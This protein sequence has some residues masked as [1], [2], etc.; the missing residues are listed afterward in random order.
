M[1]DARSQLELAVSLV[2]KLSDSTMNA[3]DWDV[4]APDSAGVLVPATDLV[5]DDAPWMLGATGLAD[6]R[7]VHAKVS[8]NVAKA[9]NIASRRSK[10]VEDQ[11]DML[12]VSVVRSLRPLLSPPPPLLLPLL[13]FLSVVDIVDA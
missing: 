13:A 7:F 1:A 12:E 10:M 4:Y 8:N 9:V 6:L 5:Y 11:A 3:C 2:Q